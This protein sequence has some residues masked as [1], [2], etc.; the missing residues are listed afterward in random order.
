MSK[1]P[2]DFRR[3]TMMVNSMEP[4]LTIYRDILGMEVYYDNEIVVT[5]VGLPAGEPN[6]KTRLVILRCNDP[7]IGMLGILQYVDPPLPAPEPR[8]V[9]NRVRAGEIVFVMHNDD[10][11]G[12]YE[13]LQKID[14]VQMVSEPHISEYPK[15]GG[16]VFRV[17]GISFFDPNGYFIELNQFVE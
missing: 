12:V 15:D 9:P 5:G 13:H 3:V 2:T 10:V 8:P 16:G 14:G 6:S 1:V 11:K 7:Y 4:A 17:L